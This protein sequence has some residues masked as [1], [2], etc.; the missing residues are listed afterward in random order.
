MKCMDE[1]TLDIYCVC[2]W[3]SLP[4]TSFMDDDDDDSFNIIFGHFSIPPPHP[5]LVWFFL[6]EL[7]LYVWKICFHMYGKT[8]D[9]KHDCVVSFSAHHWPDEH[10]MGRMSNDHVMAYVGTSH[11][12]S[13]V[14]I[15]VR[16]SVIYTIFDPLW[17]Q[18]KKI[19]W[20]YSPI[21]HSFIYM[22][23]YMDTNEKRSTNKW[24]GSHETGRVV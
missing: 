17:Q 2:V 5:P 23:I 13:L 7:S 1:W 8:F 9:C 12:L 18:R 22:Y 6:L 20:S 16:S 10:E 19:I 24:I 3:T 4:T 15:K 14:A 21:N 11:T